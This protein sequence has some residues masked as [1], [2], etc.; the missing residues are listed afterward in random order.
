MLGNDFNVTVIAMRIV[1][2]DRPVE[3]RV[4]TIIIQTKTHV[5]LEIL[6]LNLD[7]TCRY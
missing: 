1:V 5:I 6:K 7:R 3:K 2:T 4:I